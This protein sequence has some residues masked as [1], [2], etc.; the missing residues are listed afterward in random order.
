MLNTAGQFER[1]PSVP[2]V[3]LDLLVSDGKSMGEPT[4]QAVPERQAFES[5]ELCEAH[6]V[7]TGVPGSICPDA[8]GDPETTDDSPKSLLSS[9][10]S[11]GSPLSSLKAVAGLR[12]LRILG[13]DQLKIAKDV[14]GGVE[15]A[16]IADSELRRSLRNHGTEEK[17]LAG[18]RKVGRPIAYCGDPNSP[19]LTPAERRRIMRRIA[20][21][22]SARRVRARRL[23]I[24][25]EMTQKAK[26]MEEAN[27]RLLE[28]LA[29]VESKH[30]AVLSEAQALDSDLRSKS[31][32]NEELQAQVRQLRAS[33]SP[34]TADA[35]KRAVWAASGTQLPAA[36]ECS[37]STSAENLAP[38]PG[39]LGN[40]DSGS[41]LFSSLG[42]GT[43]PDGC[44]LL[45]TNAPAP[46]NPSDGAPFPL[47]T[48]AADTVMPLQCEPIDRSFSEFLNNEFASGGGTA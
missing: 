18:K 26:E 34:K 14:K 21:R 25:D 38:G 22:E 12:N 23:D 32:Q 5:L 20:N 48:A 24:L 10:S 29:S 46:G 2:L 40:A 33:L 41:I 4:L 30:N 39:M 3:D 44:A 37:F 7:T 9:L 16:S 15:T 11:I 28:R 31:A 35:A 27:A 42:Q 1:F 47:F 19:D 17:K 45:P 6:I 8:I 36:S 13:P 43:L